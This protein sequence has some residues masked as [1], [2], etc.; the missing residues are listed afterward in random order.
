[1]RGRFKLLSWQSFLILGIIAFLL[2]WKPRQHNLPTDTPWHLLTQAQ[3][4]VES[5]A[6]PDTLRSLAGKN[7][8]LTGFIYPLESGLDQHHFL[9]TPYPPSCPFHD[10]G[11]PVITIEVFARELVPFTYDAV[12]IQGKFSIEDG[13]GIRYLL[14][15]ATVEHSP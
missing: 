1:M 14:H 8:L 2:T 7:I 3:N 4:I 5:T 12:A 11:G 10:H 6:L 13:E 9:L 15:D